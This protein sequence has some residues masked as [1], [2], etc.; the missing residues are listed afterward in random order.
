MLTSSFGISETAAIELGRSN[1]QYIEFYP[2]AMNLAFD[3]MEQD[4]S[5]PHTRDE[6]APYRH[7]DI[8]VVDTAELPTTNNG[9]LKKQQAGGLCIPA[10][11][12]AAGGRVDFIRILIAAT[13]RGEFIGNSVVNSITLHELQHAH[14]FLTSASAVSQEETKLYKTIAT[15]F[16]LG[17]L[18]VTSAYFA[19]I[20]ASYETD[21]GELTGSIPISTSLGGLVGVAIWSQVRKLPAIEGEIY[22]KYYQRSF[23]ENRARATEAKA[24]DFP[25]IINIS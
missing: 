23:L 16:K 19:G 25:T 9:F 12:I 11:Y 21:I 15:R 18:A 8:E 7:I 22:D 3:Y 4:P 10:T 17:M 24:E 20:G 13:H 5:Y 2:D 6:V 14:D 1:L